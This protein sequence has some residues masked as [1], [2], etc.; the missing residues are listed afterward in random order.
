MVKE[1]Q[2]LTGNGKGVNKEAFDG[3]TSYKEEYLRE[4]EREIKKTNKW[5]MYKQRRGYFCFRFFC[6]LGD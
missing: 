2:N 3:K 6:F 1:V 4:R 5:C